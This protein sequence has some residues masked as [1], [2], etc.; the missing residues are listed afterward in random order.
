MDIHTDRPHQRFN[1]HRVE[2]DFVVLLFKKIQ[3]KK[4]KSICDHT[5]YHHLKKGLLLPTYRNCHL[6]IY[7]FQCNQNRYWFVKCYI[8]KELK[9]K[10]K[11]VPKNSHLFLSLRQNHTRSKWIQG[12]NILFI[13]SNCYYVTNKQ[14]SHFA[15]DQNWPTCI[16]HSNSNISHTF[17]DDT[18]PHTIRLNVCGA[19]K[20]RF[21]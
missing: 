18:E 21:F 4:C 5:K 7:I 1:P 17:N 15:H 12:F 16:K 13:P 19:K 10:K 11:N 3:K 2:L 9:N 8:T 14:V 6:K 20:K